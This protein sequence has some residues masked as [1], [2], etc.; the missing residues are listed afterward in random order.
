MNDIRYGQ[1]STTFSPVIVA[2]LF[3]M[4]ALHG[5]SVESVPENVS[6]SLFQ[7]IYSFGGNNPT[8]KN[9]SNSITGTFDFVPVEF[10]K[11]V[12]NFYARLLANQ[13]PLGADFEKI[14]Y[15][16]LWDL[17]ES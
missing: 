1:A 15:D 8:Y 6:E 16:N 2:G 9:Y 12:G 3:A 11:A 4:Q 10:E 13:E 14:L 5:M 17:Y 7:R